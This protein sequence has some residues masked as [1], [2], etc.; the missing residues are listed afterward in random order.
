[1]RCW[2]IKIFAGIIASCLA[3][4][5]QAAII[6]VDKNAPIQSLQNGLS[7]NDAF[8]DLADALVGALPGDEIWIAEGTYTPSAAPFGYYVVPGGV[9]LFGGF[10]GIETLP[11]DR[12]LS[13]HVTILSGD[14]D[15]NDLQNPALSFNDLQG[16]NSPWVVVCTEA[17]EMIVDG[18]TITAGASNDSVTGYGGGILMTNG[19]SRLVLRDSRIM[20]NLAFNAGGGV[21]AHEVHL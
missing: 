13:S 6:Y 17:G 1:M 20:G 14:V 21:A 8:R 7:W 4:N 16:T 3:Y 10:A 18:L 9:S 5:S 19:E 2:K 12:N 15:H 11:S